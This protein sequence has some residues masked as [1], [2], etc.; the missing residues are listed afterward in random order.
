M[1]IDSK[2]AEFAGFPVVDY[3][4]EA[5]IVFSTMPR[6]EFRSLEAPGEFL[7]VTLDGTR[8]VVE[9][10]SDG[11]IR[12]TEIQSFPTP[13]EAQQ[14]YRTIVSG[15]IQAGHVRFVER[16][17]QQRTGGQPTFWTITIAGDRHTIQAGPVGSS[18]EAE[19]TEF[20]SPT[21]A[22]ADGE[23]LIAEKIAEGYAEQTAGLASLR[24]G[25]LSALAADPDDL[26]SRMAL[27]DHLNEQGEQPPRVA[28][29]IEG[30]GYDEA[31]GVALQAF[32]ADP[33]VSLIEAVVIG[34][35]FGHDGGGS[36]DV[37]EMLVKARDRLPN[38]RALF[39]GDLTYR[40]QEISW[41]TLSDVTALL[42]AFPRLEHFRARGGN[43]LV[44]QP[45]EHAHLKSLTFEASN[46]P[47]ELVRAVGES[48]LPALEHLELWLGTSEYGADTTVADLQGIFAGTHLPALRYLGL[49]NS[50]IADAVAVAVGS[51][52]I[53]P[54]LRVLDLSLGTLGNRG[55]EALL[56]IPALA[57]LE[58]LDIHH[59]Y[60]DPALVARLQALGIEVDASDAEV[61]DDPEDPDDEYPVDDRFVAHA[62]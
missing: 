23:R 13:A 8:L 56:A 53:L 57:G 5:G 36:D 51:A 22:R 32:L 1:V 7:A 46:L 27:A 50:E 14:G 30:E 3:H 54:R 35:C 16:T 61:E 25:I 58:K 52:A 31:E 19:T 55:A 6:R 15:Q 2:A 34:F 11:T 60:V 49:R 44:L 47:R 26:A 33:A 45:I 39:L 17:F 9:V 21:E 24:E 12:D 10:G 18:G 59:H 4:P 29:R 42:T 43:G 28:Y 38:L 41:I 62:E 37:I 48:R 20:E 40:D